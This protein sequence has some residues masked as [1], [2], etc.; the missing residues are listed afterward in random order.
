MQDLAIERDKAVKF[1]KS[2]NT[3]GNVPQAAGAANNKFTSTCRVGSY[4]CR[5][6]VYQDPGTYL[7]DLIARYSC[8]STIAIV[9]ARTLY[10]TR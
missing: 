2:M 7:S 10:S 5:Y 3:H 9:L 8:T 4:S 6:T 1:C